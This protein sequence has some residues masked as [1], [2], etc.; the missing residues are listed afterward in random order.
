LSALRAAVRKHWER[1]EFYRYLTDETVFPIIVTL[2]EEEILLFEGM[3]VVPICKLNSF[4]NEMER[5]L[6][7]FE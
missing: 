3:P 6:C 7:Q 1:S 2:L 4:L 5:G